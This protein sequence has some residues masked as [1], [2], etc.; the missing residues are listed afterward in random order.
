MLPMEA[1]NHP[2]DVWIKE[3]ENYSFVQL[4]IK[5]SPTA[6]SLGQ[7]YGHLMEDTHFYLAQATLAAS[8]DEHAF[9]EASPTAKGMF[10]RNTF[11]DEIIEGAPA[12][13]LI[14]Q[15]D[16]GQQL[17]N[18]LLNL[19]EKMRQVYELVSTSPYKGKTKHPGLGYFSAEEW[20][21]FADMHFRHHL[22]QK[23]RID[24]FIKMHRAQ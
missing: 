12:N 13:A 9:E 17:M 3:L 15:P 24:R 20:L 5:P 16:S 8:T 18:G 21:R 10:L 7:L 22:R 23:Q 1:L 2:I 11:P 4:C 19:K 14:P 6:W